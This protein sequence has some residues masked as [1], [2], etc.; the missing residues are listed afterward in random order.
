MGEFGVMA[1][2]AA[3]FLAAGVFGGIKAGIF[4]QNKE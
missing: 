2:A 4:V 1:R 3:R